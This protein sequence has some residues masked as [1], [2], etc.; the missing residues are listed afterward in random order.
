[1][2]LEDGLAA[3]AAGQHAAESAAPAAWKDAARAAVL[4]MV[5]AGLEFTA[6]DVTQRVGCPNGEYTGERDTNGAV[7]SLF[8]SL[9]KSKVIEPTGEL[10]R[11]TR[12]ESHASDLRVWR[13]YT[14]RAARLKAATERLEHWMEPA[15]DSRFGTT[16]TRAERHPVTF[17]REMRKVWDQ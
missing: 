9:G 2:S 13:A 5:E 10:R 11:C 8:S 7:G 1:M 6:E 4:E 17:A 15:D 14:G 12:T 16:L 3:K